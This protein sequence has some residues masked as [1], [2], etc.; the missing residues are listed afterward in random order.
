M[1]EIDRARTE[2]LATA[3]GR[4]VIP[5]LHDQ[6]PR[7][8]NVYV[9]LNALAAIAAAVIAAAADRDALDFFHLAL[10]QNIIEDF[11]GA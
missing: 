3:I 10:T 9:C 8:D 7:R 1:S 4:L 2:C 11:E 5:L 6:P